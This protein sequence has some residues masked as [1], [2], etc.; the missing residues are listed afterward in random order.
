MAT[1][2][3]LWST[4]LELPPSCIAFCPT[5][6]DLI[7]VGTYYLHNATSQREKR[8]HNDDE[9]VSGADATSAAQ[10]RSGSLL[11]YQIRD[12]DGVMM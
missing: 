1:T 3:S 10:S 9:T 7:V 5:E 4:T 8:E 2:Q 11:L 12:G 6:P